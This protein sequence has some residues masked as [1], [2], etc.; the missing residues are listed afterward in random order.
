MFVA[1]IIV[2]IVTL[3]EV[4]GLDTAI[5]GVRATDPELLNIF[6]GMTFIGIVSTVSWGLGI[7]DNHTS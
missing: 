1:L 5:A 7:L 4:G 2:P 3:M 6:R